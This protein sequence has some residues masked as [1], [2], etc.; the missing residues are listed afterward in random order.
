M[1][2]PKAGDTDRQ[3]EKDLIHQTKS[4]WLQKLSSLDQGGG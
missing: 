4:A 3:K 2:H 1:N